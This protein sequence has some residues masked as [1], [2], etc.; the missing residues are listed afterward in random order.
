L[1]MNRKIIHSSQ[2]LSQLQPVFTPTPASKTNHQGG[3]QISANHCKSIILPSV[4]TIIICQERSQ[5]QVNE[6][7]RLVFLPIQCYGKEE[8]LQ[9]CD[10]SLRCYVMLCLCFVFCVETMVSNL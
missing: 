5:Q 7:H 9:Q 3:H 10:V 1:A 4:C 8:Y 2:F 6:Q